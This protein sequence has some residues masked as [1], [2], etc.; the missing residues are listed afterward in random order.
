MIFCLLFQG[1]VFSPQRRGDAGITGNAERI[2]YSK[3]FK[4]LAI[5]FTLTITPA[6]AGVTKRVKVIASSKKY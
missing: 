2:F 5:T 1:K 3:D 4:R 6:F